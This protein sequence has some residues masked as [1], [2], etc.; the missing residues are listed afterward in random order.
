ML[1]SYKHNPRS[2]DDALKSIKPTNSFVKGNAYAGGLKMKKYVHNPNSNKNALNVQAPGRAVARIRDYQGN[3]KMNKPLGKNLLPDAQ[4]AHGFRDNVKQDR[5][6]L[7]NIKLKWAKLFK[8]NAVQ[9]D[10][11]KEKVR[12]PRYDKKER[13]LWKDLYD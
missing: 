13:D 10:A 5:T 1:W 2:N 4:F 7:M 8:K 11:V 9:P 12:K 6:L 3:L